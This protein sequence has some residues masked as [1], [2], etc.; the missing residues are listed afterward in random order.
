MLSNFIAIKKFSSL[1]IESISIRSVFRFILR[2]ESAPSIEKTEEV[3]D[4]LQSFEYLKK[5][6]HRKLNQADLE[7]LL[8][9]VSAIKESFLYQDKKQANN[10]ASIINFAKNQPIDI[11]SLLNKR[12]GF[13]KAMDIIPQPKASNLIASE[14]WRSEL[15]IKP[16]QINNKKIQSAHSSASRV[17]C[18]NDLNKKRIDRAA[19]KSRKSIST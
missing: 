10:I 18:T 11:G 6:Q 15:G 5:N 12:R 7:A 2:K 13:H 1:L 14:W 3:I 16:L 19:V 17:K 4:F 9:E 8:K